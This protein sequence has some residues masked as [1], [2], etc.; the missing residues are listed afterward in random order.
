MNIDVCGEPLK[1]VPRDVAHHGPGAAVV[2]A[3]LRSESHERVEAGGWLELSDSE[4]MRA[5]GFNREQLHVELYRLY[6]RRII[7]GKTSNGGRRRYRFTPAA[8][9]EELEG[10][11]LPRNQDGSMGSRRIDVG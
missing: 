6:F 5:T 8:A 3:V 2:L 9:V 10:R 4:F 11:P 1:V 7:Q